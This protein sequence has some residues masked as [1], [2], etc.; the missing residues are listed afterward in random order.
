MSDRPMG[1]L[2]SAQGG[3]LSASMETYPMRRSPDPPPIYS[4]RWKVCVEPTCVVVM[5]YITIV[6]YFSKS[7][8]SPIPRGSAS[9]VPG[10]SCRPKG[11]TVFWGCLA[12]VQSRPWSWWPRQSWLCATWTSASCGSSCRPAP[13]TWLCRGLTRVSTSEPH[14]SSHV[15]LLLIIY[16]AFKTARRFGS[17]YVSLRKPSRCPQGP[18]CAS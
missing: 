3:L 16:A 15:G 4:L 7:Q 2:L 17:S 11:S 14:H 5:N 10:S 18:L 12:A 13:G 8:L 1:A 6:I 9:P